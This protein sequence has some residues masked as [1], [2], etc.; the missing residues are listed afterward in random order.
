MYEDRYYIE[1][2]MDNTNNIS[3][4]DLISGIKSLKKSKNNTFNNTDEVFTLSSLSKKKK[5]KKK[6]KIKNELIKN[7]KVIDDNVDEKETEMILD[8]DLIDVDNLLSDDEDD[9][10]DDIIDEQRHGYNKLKKESNPYKKEFAE[11]LT[12]L[13]N[14]LDESSKFGKKL[15]K[16]FEGMEKSKTRGINKYVNDLILSI[17]SS[18]SNKLQILKEISGVKKS[19]ID[20][21]IKSDSKEKTNSGQQSSEMLASNYF[22]NVLKYGRN[23]F[24]RDF[25][26]KDDYDDYDETDELINNIEKSKYEDYSDEEMDEYNDIIDNRLDEEGNPYRSDEG[27]KYI[28]YEKRG[29]KIFIKKCIDTGDWEFVALDKYQQQIFDYPLPSRKSAGKVK[30]SEDGKYCSDDKGRTYKVIEYYLPDEQENE[31][32]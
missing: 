29:V 22:K 2:N 7:G 21:K 27:S 8:E 9:I 17:L 1:I 23:N 31:D 3:R 6:K 18:K 19:I 30:F 10:D 12:L 26:N 25:K 32:E 13:Y 28:E 4:D 5:G 20:L 11:E 16:M 14:L 24:I 15:D